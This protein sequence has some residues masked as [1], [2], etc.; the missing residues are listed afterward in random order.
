MTILKRFKSQKLAI[1]ALA[2]IF[3][4]A[5]SSFTYAQVFTINAGNS[6]ADTQSL[7]GDET[8]LV[9]ADGEIAGDDDG[10]DMNNNNN[11]LNNFGLIDVDDSADGVVIDN[12]DNN[13][14]NN[15]NDIFADDDGVV[16]TNGSGGNIV[17]NFADGVIDV[18]GDGVEISDDANNNTVNNFNLISGDDDGIV[19]KNGSDDNIVN[20]FA[21]GV[22]EGNDDGVDI[23][24]D[25][26]SNTVNNW[27]LIEGSDGVD[28]KENADFNTVNNWGLIEGSDDGVDINEN[29]NNNTVNNWGLIEGNDDGVEIKDNANSNTVNNW[30]H[31]LANDDEGNA[32]GVVI[33][34]GSDNNT[35]NNWGLIEGSD[36][37]VQIKNGS[38]GNTV[39]NYGSII[40]K[41]HGIFLTGND[42]SGGNTIN[43]YG[44]I[45][46]SDAI[47]SRG[48]DNTL[49]LFSRS[50]IIGRIVMNGDKGDVVNIFFNK[51]GTSSTLTFEGLDIGLTI[52]PP[53]NLKNDNMMQ[54]DISTIDNPA[55]FAIVV[56][57]TGPSVQGAA[58]GTLTDKIHGAITNHLLNGPPGA[59]QLA[60]TRVEPGMMN[61]G[62]G[63]QFWISGF[64]AHRERDEDGRALAY[65]HDIAGGVAGYETGFRQFRVGVLGGYAHAD[66]V[67]DTVS[68]D[69]NTDSWFVGG[70]GQASFGVI[71]LDVALLAGYEQNDN[72]RWLV[73]NLNG[74]EVAQSEFDS[75]F[76]SPSATVSAEFM[77]MGNIALRP[78]AT[79]SYSVA[80]YNSYTEH[81]T[82]LSNLSIDDRTAEAFIAKLQLGTAYIFSKG[83]E[84]EFRIGGR[85]R[86]TSDDDIDATLAGT[87]FRYAAVGD[88]DNLEGYFG[89]NLRLAVK[90]WVSLTADMEYSIND[91]E[92]SISGFAGLEFT[93]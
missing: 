54:M 7:D 23:K 19:I 48:I 18:E 30:G 9:E 79:A 21:D 41:D 81:G 86:N 11:I 87:S 58:L 31:I 49:N 1:S 80:W 45:R 22:I 40:A 16:I 62:K 17:N 75:Y 43:N 72:H 73:D 92:D 14:V 76:L 51:A 55:T 36:D 74:I 37:G 68:N 32:D 88:D 38:D 89:G 5:C 82:T 4:L 84:F 2:L 71:K 93:F 47:L 69:T 46:G 3:L 85:Y 29:A 10:V 34:D 33:A 27:G 91:M 53:I 78:S 42:G 44:K 65:D 20:N 15:F 70:Y 6:P 77:V 39:N 35:I 66:V 60:S 57:P 50:Q 56:D 67:T 24:D 26:N 52:P 64:A 83:N 61:P 90:D 28:I 59:Q 13:T 12:A 25:A 63:D 8:G